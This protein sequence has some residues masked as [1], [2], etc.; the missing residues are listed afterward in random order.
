[1][2]ANGHAAIAYELASA[3]WGRGL[4]SEAVRA[5][6]GELVQRYGA[7]SL[8]AVLKRDNQRSLRLLQRLGF[9]LASP[10]AHVQHRVEPGD[11]LMERALG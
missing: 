1:V 2:H 7:R 4:A 8:G 10:D 6:I 11:L 5:V 9:T 3:W